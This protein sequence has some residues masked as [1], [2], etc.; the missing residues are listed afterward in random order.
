MGK[1]RSGMVAGLSALVARKGAEFYIKVLVACLALS[2]ITGHIQVLQWLHR[3]CLS[4]PS[5]ERL[6]W[7][8]G[9]LGDL[10]LR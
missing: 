10:P 2:P 1:I 3:A 9:M 5:P 7:A 6:P 8:T 4:G